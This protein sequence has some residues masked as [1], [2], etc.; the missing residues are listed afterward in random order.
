MK[1]VKVDSRQL[2]YWLF[3]DQ[4]IPAFQ[5][6]FGVGYTLS[7]GRSDVKIKLL[8]GSHPQSK[9][10]AWKWA[11][12]FRVTAGTDQIDFEHVVLHELTHL[13]PDT[14]AHNDKFY[15][16]LKKV[17]KWAGADMGYAISREGRY[18]PRNSAALRKGR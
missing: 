12:Y 3:L 10:T 18:K 7:G 4:I 5:K 8:F 14:E 15:R 16:Q 17:L 6:K 9:G 11:R 13:L 2:D 1:I